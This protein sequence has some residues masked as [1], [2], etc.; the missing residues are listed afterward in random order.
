MNSHGIIGH[1]GLALAALA[2]A[3]LAGS[4]HESSAAGVKREFAVVNSNGTLARGALAAS[5][6]RVL[7][8]VYHVTFKNDVRE[9]AYVA[10]VGTSVPNA[11]QGGGSPRTFNTGGNGHTIEVRIG[12]QG[13][14]VDRG[15]HL[16]IVC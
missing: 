9:C 16:V 8:G 1:S 10:T 4:S 13:E 3:S 2:A 7:T 15:F 11:D 14:A 5:S 6:I 12:Q